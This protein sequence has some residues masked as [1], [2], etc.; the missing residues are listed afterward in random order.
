MP[1]EQRQ[2]DAELHLATIEA[3][4][5]AIDAKERS[6]NHVWRVQLTPHGW[7][8]HWAYRREIQ[9]I[10]AAAL[11]TTSASSPSLNTSYRSQDRWPTR[12]SRRFAAV[13]GAEI[14]SG[15]AFPYPV[16]AAILSHHERWDGAGYPH[17]LQGEAI[18]LGARILSIVDYFDSATSERPYH[19]P[20]AHGE[21]AEL[22]MRESGA[23]LDPRLVATFIE[24]LPSLLEESA[25]QELK[26]SRAIGLVAGPAGLGSQSADPVPDW[27]ESVF[28]N[29]ALAH[30]EVY[31]MRYRAID[32]TSP[33]LSTR[34]R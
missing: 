8:R 16:A 32:D 31:P 25:A 3:L 10:K 7:R 11:F 20:L 28:E 34:W 18:P 13:V 9:G 21:A 15:V 23:A 30:R 26:T 27:P 5:R 33:E 4:A 19:R 17:Q 29:I 14:I 24:L 22:I 2:T 12:S 1:R 6:H